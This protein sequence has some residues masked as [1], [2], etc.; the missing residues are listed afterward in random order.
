[1]PKDLGVQFPALPRLSNTLGKSLL[2]FEAQ[3]FLP[4]N[5]R[6]GPDDLYSFQVPRGRMGGR[7]P[8]FHPL[9]E[10]EPKLQAHK[11]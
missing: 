1:M 10:A 6:V 7:F 5:E 8:C 3:L 2:L 11:G 4:Q 9:S